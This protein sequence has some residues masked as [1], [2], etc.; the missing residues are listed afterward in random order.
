MHGSLCNLHLCEV[1]LPLIGHS[2]GNTQPSVWYSLIFS[3]LPHNVYVSDQQHTRSCL[4]GAKDGS[5]IQHKWSSAVTICSNYRNAW[6]RVQCAWPLHM[7]L[8]Q[9]QLAWWGPKTNHR[10][11][12]CVARLAA[13]RYANS[14]WLSEVI[15]Q[16]A[17]HLSTHTLRFFWLRLIGLRRFRL[18]AI[19]TCVE[20]MLLHG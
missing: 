2:S 19:D 11:L 7:I 5:H 10:P 12:H 18:E 6:L 14:P 15:L 17:T 13:H 8:H 3:S 20:G 16:W 1:T 4:N 9:A